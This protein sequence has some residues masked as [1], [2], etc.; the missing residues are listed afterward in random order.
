MWKNHTHPQQHHNLAPPHAGRQLG[1]M[2]LWDCIPFS[3]ALKWRVVGGGPPTPIVSPLLLYENVAVTN[4]MCECARLVL[5]IKSKGNKWRLF[6]SAGDQGGNS[7][8]NGPPPPQLPQY[9]WEGEGPWVPLRFYLTF[10]WTHFFL[11]FNLNDGENEMVK[12]V[13]LYFNSPDTSIRKFHS[14]QS[15]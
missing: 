9:P 2:L 11:F 10:S 12:T 14:K 15:E 3:T 7:R 8:A 13:G 4:L 6:C 1:R 5:C